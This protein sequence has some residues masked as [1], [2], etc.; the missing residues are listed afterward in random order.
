MRVIFLDFDGVLH[1]LG[2]QLT[3]TRVVNGKPVA[4]VVKVD[5]FCWVELLA[6]KLER[7]PDVRLVVHSA[8]RESHTAEALGLYL[9]PLLPR[10]IG[11]TDNSPK[12]QSIRTWL[13]AHPDVHSFCILDD[14]THEFDCDPPVPEF[15]ACNYETGITAPDVLKQLDV[16]LNEGGRPISANL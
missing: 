13:A 10:Y 15:I 7:F 2:L 5:F 8:W 16:W 9:G 14:A 6:Q 11:C 12:L 1:P 4:T 3:D